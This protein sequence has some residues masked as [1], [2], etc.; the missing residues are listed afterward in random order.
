MIPVVSTMMPTPIMPAV[1]S[2]PAAM[3]DADGASLGRVGLRCSYGRRMLIC[4][5]GPG[6]AGHEDPQ[7]ESNS[8]NNEVFHFYQLR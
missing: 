2:V 3:P 5:S 4:M 8:G 1:P 7:Y 6:Q